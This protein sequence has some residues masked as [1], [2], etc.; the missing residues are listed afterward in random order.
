MPPGSFRIEDRGGNN[1]PYTDVS[2]IPIR[3]QH[4]RAELYVLA[5]LGTA[6]MKAFVTIAGND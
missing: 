3:A 1:V 6:L 5:S 4:S 2:L